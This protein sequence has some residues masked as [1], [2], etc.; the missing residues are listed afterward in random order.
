[1]PRSFVESGSAGEEPTRTALFT[2]TVPAVPGSTTA[3]TFSHASAPAGSA[4]HS[5]A[6]VA[7]V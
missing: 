3:R 2:I 5:H 7:G 4:P 6:P 1:M